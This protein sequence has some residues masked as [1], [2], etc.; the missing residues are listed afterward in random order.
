MYISK[1]KKL[2]VIQRW[3]NL[4]EKDQD[5]QLNVGDVKERTHV[6]IFLIRETK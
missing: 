2:R 5:E 3:Y 6:D 1:S 4:H